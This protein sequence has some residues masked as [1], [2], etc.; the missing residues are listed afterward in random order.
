MRGAGL[1]VARDI[2]RAETVERELDGLIRRR[3]D[4]RAAE[5]RHRPSEE[6]YEE[7]CRRH[8]EEEARQKLVAIYRFEVE[9]LARLDN[10]FGVLREEH[11]AKRDRAAAALLREFQLTPEKLGHELQETA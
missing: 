4:Q 9:H 11:E 5:N 2:S 3:H 7:S 6:L 8:A 10:T 1:D